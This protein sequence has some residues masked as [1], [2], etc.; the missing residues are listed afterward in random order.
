[1]QA[2]ARGEDERPVRSEVAEQSIGAENTFETDIADLAMAQAWLLRL[3][4]KISGRV[5]TRAL[6]GRTVTVKLRE[7]P[8]VTHTRQAQLALA[9]DATPDI[10]A[11]ARRLLDAWWQQQTRPRLRLLGVSLS[12]FGERAQHDLFAAP[13]DEPRADGIQ[14]RINQKFGAGSLVRAGV[15]KTR[16]HD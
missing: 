4:E 13:G 6:K 10:Y 5:R 2:L 14:D 7:P 9:G 8:F 15:L 16:G 12:G 11:V 1:L 3:C